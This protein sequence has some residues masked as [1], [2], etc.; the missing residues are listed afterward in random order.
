MLA[1]DDRLYV[2][3]MTIPAPIIYRDLP[4]PPSGAPTLGDI[5]LDGSAEVLLSDTVG[6]VR[7]SFSRLWLTLP[8]EV[9]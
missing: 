4:A 9:I 5:D 3:S 2:K 1:F 7:K 6:F 8:T